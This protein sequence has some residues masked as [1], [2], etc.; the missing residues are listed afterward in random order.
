[1][2]EVID[3]RVAE[4]YRKMTPQQRVHRVFELFEMGRQMMA[5][6]IRQ[7][8]PLLSAAEVESLVTRRLLDARP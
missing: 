2:V 6:G 3:D 4:I 8:S 7:R 1:M 5:G